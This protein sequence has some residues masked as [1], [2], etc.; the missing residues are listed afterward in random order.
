MNVTDI[1]TDLQME[2]QAI[3][4]RLAAVVHTE[5]Q[6]LHQACLHL[7]HAGGKRLRPVFVLLSGRYGV[8]SFDVLKEVAVV[9][10]LIHMATLVHDDVI[11][12]ADMRR[13]SPTVKAEWNEQVAMRTGEFLFARALQQMAQFPQPEVQR[14]LSKAILHM[15]LGEIRQIEDQFKRDISLKQYLRRIKRKTS[16]LIAVSCQLGALVSEAP[17]SVAQKLYQY[18]YSIGMAFQI[19]DDILDFTSDEHVLGKPAGNDV[20]QGNVTLPFLYAQQMGTE[21]DRARL[22]D[23]LESKGEAVPLPEVVA[24]VKKS[25]GLAYAF[26]ISERYLA[27]AEEAIRQLP[28]DSSGQALEAVAHYIL[29]RSY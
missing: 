9:L 10:E 14:I 22:L 16:L 20:K 23:Y 29:Q 15:C 6:T 7:L 25:G 19:I 21:A 26:Q 24:I 17:P 13:G 27:K 12:C 11:D 1:Y 5:E 2:L 8:A 4:S 3:E 18:G 28:S